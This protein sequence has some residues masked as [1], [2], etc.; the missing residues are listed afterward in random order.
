MG[1]QQSTP[2]ERL[3]HRG[4][5]FDFAVATTIGRSGRP[6]EREVVRHPGAVILVP[7]LE[8][9]NER[10]P[11]LLFVRQHRVATGSRIL[12]LPAGTLE[13]GE[14]PFGCAARELEEETGFQAATVRTLGRFY[15]SPGMS[16][17]V[18]HAF[19][20]TELTE[21]EPAPED[22][23]DIEVVR[24]GMNEV[25]QLIAA[26]DLADGKSLAAIALGVSQ[27]VLPSSTFSP[28]TGNS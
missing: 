2:S 13:H 16:D 6:I 7:L 8:S 15:P 5:K 21:T 9:N 11:E 4:R 14:N 25:A 10:G 20:A 17:E 3:I 26:G 12:E 22:D 28:S 23:E 27:G 24:V 19:V 18:M 1:E